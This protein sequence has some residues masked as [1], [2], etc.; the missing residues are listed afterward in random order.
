M[1]N[2]FVAWIA[3]FLIIEQNNVQRGFIVNRQIKLQR[4]FLHG[5]PSYK[6]GSRMKI[7]LPSPEKFE[8]NDNAFANRGKLGCDR[9]Y[10]G[11]PCSVASTLNILQSTRFTY[12]GMH[13]TEAISI[14]VQSIL[15]SLR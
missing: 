4:R 12:C 15:Y 13:E 14:T 2:K 10:Q 3:W 6:T 11:F 5:T 1:E 8:R 7:V 9:L